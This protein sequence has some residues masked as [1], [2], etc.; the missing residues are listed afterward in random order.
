MGWAEGIARGPLLIGVAPVE[1]RERGGGVGGGP[2]YGK[3]VSAD[4]GGGGSKP[5]GRPTAPSADLEHGSGV[6]P[7]PQPAASAERGV[8][9]C[10]FF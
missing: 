6:S 1:T 8:S 2:R 3:A 5:R 10:A 7:R 9:R 4:L